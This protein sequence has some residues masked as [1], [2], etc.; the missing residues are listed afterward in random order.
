MDQ[1]AKEGTWDQLK[2]HPMQLVK[3]V[4][5]G[6]ADVVGKDKFGRLIYHLK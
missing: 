4:I 1:K 3:M 2:I 6:K 5:Q